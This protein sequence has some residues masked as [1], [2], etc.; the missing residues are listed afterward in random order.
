MLSI[1]VGNISKNIAY[2]LLDLILWHEKPAARCDRE[3]IKALTANQLDGIGTLIVI[4]SN[5][6]LALESLI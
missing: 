3:S 5:I 6:S 4:N 2:I 1:L